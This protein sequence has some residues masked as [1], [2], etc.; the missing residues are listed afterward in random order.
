VKAISW[1]A[2]RLAAADRYVI[3]VRWHTADAD[4]IKLSVT[5]DPHDAYPGGTVRFT[6]SDGGSG[7][8]SALLPEVFDRFRPPAGSG[9]RMAGRTGRT[10]TMT[11]WQGSRRHD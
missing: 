2:D 8:P 4:V 9:R 5:A 1:L 7:I 6:V 3:R 10:R 11:R